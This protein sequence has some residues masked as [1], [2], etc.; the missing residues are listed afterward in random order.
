M[1]ISST[2]SVLRLKCLRRPKYLLRPKFL[3]RPKSCT[4]TTQLRPIGDFE[5]HFWEKVER[6]FL[7]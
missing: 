4:S 3:F 1:R 2:L 6:K 7:G 5:K